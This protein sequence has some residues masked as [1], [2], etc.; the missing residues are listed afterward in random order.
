MLTGLADNPLSFINN[1]IFDFYVENSNQSFEK[2]EIVK[3]T[4]TYSK[5]ISVKWGLVSVKL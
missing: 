5:L 2:G 3:K 1:L 4:D